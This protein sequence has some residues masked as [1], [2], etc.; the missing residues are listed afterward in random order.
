MRK[1]EFAGDSGFI[2]SHV[3]DHMSDVG[4]HVT[5][6]N[7]N[8]FLWLRCGK[9]IVIGDVQDRRKLDETIAGKYIIL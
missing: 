1:A 3:A 6:L 4:F 2:G 5:I 9:E 7:R 8:E